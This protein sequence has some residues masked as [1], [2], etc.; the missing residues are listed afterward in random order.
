MRCCAAQDTAAKLLFSIF[1]YLMKTLVL[2]A[3][4]K[5]ESFNHAIADTV[6]RS[7]KDIGHEPILHD[8]YAERFD[9]VLPVE[10]LTLANEELPGPLKKY[11]AEIQEAKGLVFVHPNWWGNPPAILAGWL[12]RILRNRFAY[13]FTE[14]GPVPLLGDKIVQVFSTS[15]T[16][17]EVELNVYHDPLEN[18]W[19]TIVFGLCGCESLERRNFESIILSTPGQRNAWLREVGEIIHRRFV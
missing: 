9:P 14:K 7:L 11:Q 1:H 2:L 16:P 17:R 8:L 19:K 15:N 12:D 10:E 13:S 5:S 3:H 18:F 4:P 6:C